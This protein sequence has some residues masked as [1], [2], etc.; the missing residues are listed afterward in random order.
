MFILR[1]ANTADLPAIV[2]IYNQAIAAG[3]AT[4]DTTPFTVEARLDW[5]NTHS[6][7][8][9]PIYVC[10]TDNGQVLGWLSLSP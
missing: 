4:A 3:N 2:S 7:D 6:A 9:Y 8:E 5:F 10:E 1:L